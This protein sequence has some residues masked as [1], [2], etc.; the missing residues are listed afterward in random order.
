[1]DVSPQMYYDHGSGQCQDPVVIESVGTTII[2]GRFSMSYSTWHSSSVQCP[3]DLWGAKYR[4]MKSVDLS[5]TICNIENMEND[6]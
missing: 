2:T 4:S 1:M 3:A 6:I 5:L